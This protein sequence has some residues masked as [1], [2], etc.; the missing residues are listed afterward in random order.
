MSEVQLCDSSQRSW[1]FPPQVQPEFVPCDHCGSTEE[2]VLFE[3][4][5]RLHRLPGI[6]RLVQCLQCGWIRQNP[7]PTI[8]TIGYYYPS[9]YVNFVPAIEDEPKPW[10]RWDRRYGILKRRWAVERLQPRGR[11]LD[12]GC[13]TGIFLHEMQQAGWDVVGVEPNPE[14]ADYAQKRFGLSVHV[15]LLRQVGLPGSSFDVITLWDVLEHLH[16]PWADLIEMHRL[17]RNKGLLVVRIPNLE[18]P[19]ARWFGPL[20]VGWDLPR[21][22]YLF[23]R[24]ALVAAL[25]EIGFAVE[26]IRCISTS[27]SAFTLSLRFYLEDRYPPPKQ[28]PQWILQCLGTMPIR[29]AVGPLFWII[30]QARLSSLITIF[31]RKRAVGETWV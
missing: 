22:L 5:D 4:P 27:Y 31:A 28:W 15:G 10:R 7:R 25:S 23:P 9:C 6:F 26:G 1:W 16:T 3:G 12:V 18:S 21:H 13:A 2:R 14:A 17:L 11:L 19:A 30:N 24:R 8:E 20:W 29:L